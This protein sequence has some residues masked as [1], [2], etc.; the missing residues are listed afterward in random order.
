MG[1]YRGT[2]KYCPQ[3]GSL[4]KPAAEPN[5]STRKWI[6]TLA[7]VR[8]IAATRSTNF[9]TF[10]VPAGPVRNSLRSSATMERAYEES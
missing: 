4:T 9:E 6:G 5:A 7:S 8:A 2:G 10:C 1:K 3:A